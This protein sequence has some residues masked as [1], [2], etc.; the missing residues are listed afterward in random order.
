MG[1]IGYTVFEDDGGA[2]W[3]AAFSQRPSAEDVSSILAKARNAKYLNDR[4]A[5]AALCCAEIVAAA[6]G[7]PVQ[8][9]PK[10]LLNWSVSTDNALGQLRDNARHAI[11]VVCSSSELSE[12]WGEDPGWSA[13]TDGLAGRLG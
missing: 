10:V 13:Y 11:S 8:T 5:I 2:D 12:I 6:L 9:M 1:A 7:S 3:A 4:E